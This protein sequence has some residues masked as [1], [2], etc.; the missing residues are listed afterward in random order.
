MSVEQEHERR[1]ACR[2]YV[3]GQEA[4]FLSSRAA[5]L[6]QNARDNNTCADGCLGWLR[7]AAVYAEDTLQDTLLASY[8]ASCVKIIASKQ[9]MLL[10][11][12]AAREP[13]QPIAKRFVLTESSS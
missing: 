12:E 2:R 8:L 5:A 3:R 13:L 11:E 1:T 7:R 4:A 6:L 9:S 10:A